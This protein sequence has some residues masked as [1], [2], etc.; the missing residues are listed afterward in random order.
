M[1]VVYLHRSNN[2]SVFVV[3]MRIG[4]NHYD[5]SVLEPHTQ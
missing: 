3:S 1:L 4:M 2:S 5:A